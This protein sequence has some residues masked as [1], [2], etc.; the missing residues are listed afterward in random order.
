MLVQSFEGMT[1]GLAVGP[2]F[3]EMQELAGNGRLPITN[4]SIVLLVPKANP[5][6]PPSSHHHQWDARR[7]FRTTKPVHFYVPL[8]MRPLGPCLGYHLTAS[9]HLGVTPTLCMLERFYWRGR[10]NVCI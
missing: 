1:Y 4:N 6:Y 8:L 7:V 9:C 5:A 2:S 10:M 3:A